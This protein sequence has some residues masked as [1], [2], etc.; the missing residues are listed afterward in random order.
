MKK[1]A[2]ILLFWGTLYAQQAVDLR[3]PKYQE[4]FWEVY[5]NA[6][7]GDR[8]A[9]FQVGV[10][11]ERGIG[12][13]QNQTQAALWYEKS[14]WQGYVHAQYNLALMY[15][16]G[17]G[18]DKNLERAMAWLSKAAKQGD[19]EARGLL[20]EIIDG[21]H[22]A[23]EQV[24]PEGNVE[25]VET[26]IIPVTLVTKEGA[27]VCDGNGEC[28]AY[29]EKTVLTSTA[30]KGEYYKISGIVTKQGWKRFGGEGWISENDV[31][32]RR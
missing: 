29:R 5:T 19:R 22:D 13:D 8:I 9:E 7:R 16:S 27:K 25:G 1:I 4:S 32:R 23:D 14:A 2:A 11:Y 12:V 26:P 6:L 24:S 10:L 28:V 17:R 18:V 15:A 31:E 21:K 3:Q 30:K 20:L